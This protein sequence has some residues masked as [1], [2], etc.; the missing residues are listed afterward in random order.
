MLGQHTHEGLHEARHHATYGLA[1]ALALSGLAC[2]TSSPPPLGTTAGEAESGEDETS[3]EGTA[4]ASDT[5]TTSTTTSTTAPESESDTEPAEVRCASV[6][7]SFEANETTIPV[8]DG[9]TGAWYVYNDETEGATQDPPLCEPFLP[10]DEFALEG[11]YAARTSGSGF[12]EWGAG[13]GV[14]LNNAG[15]DPETVAECEVDFSNRLPYDASTYTGI[16]FYGKSNLDRANIRVKFPTVIDTPD[17]EGGTCTNGDQCNNSFHAI[18]LLGTE[19]TGV[20]IE[21]SD[22]RPAS[23]G[24]SFE[25]DLTQ[26]IGIQ[27]EHQANRDFDFSIDKLCF[28]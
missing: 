9:R 10:D 2:A 13:I 22:L 25:F 7:D 21:F 12:T 11:L 26:L 4:S 23:F 16:S 28:F 27:F 14:D 6:I 8:E 1:L 17:G 15:Y 19:W 24:D 18:Q 20:E 5:S 3:N